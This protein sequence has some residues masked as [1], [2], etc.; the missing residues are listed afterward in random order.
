MDVHPLVEARRIW[1]ML[2]DAERRERLAQLRERQRLA[3]ERDLRRLRPSGASTVL[4]VGVGTDV[5][6]VRAEAG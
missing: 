2:P 1:R 5:E 3:V 4:D 6:P